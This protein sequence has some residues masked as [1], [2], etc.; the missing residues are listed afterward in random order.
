MQSVRTLFRHLWLG[1]PHLASEP[2]T[3]MFA[4]LRRRL[5]LWYTGVLAGML[6]LFGVVLYLSLDHLLLGPVNT[7]LAH[8]A[9]RYGA[10]WQ[11]AADRDCP[12][13]PDRGEGGINQGQALL[14]ACFNAD[15][16]FQ[17]GYLASNIALSSD[18]FLS[19]SLVNQ[20]LQTGAPQHDIINEGDQ[21]GDVYR[22]AE[23]VVSGPDGSILG[24]IQV[25]ESVDVE[26]AALHLLLILLLILGATTLFA[27]AMGG[28]FLAERALA[29][30]HL[31]FTRQQA[32]IADASHELRTPLTLLR[33]DA[34]V[35]LS[36]RERLAPDDAALLE[37]IV[38]ESEHMTSLANNM[39]TLA[40]LD[41]GRFHLERDVVDLAAVAAGAVHRA[42]AFAQEKQ[43]ALHLEHAGP[44]LVVGDR[45]LLEQAAIILLDNAIKYNRPGG[46]VH[47]SASI[48]GGRACLEISDT[49]M[50]I[51]AEHM[52]HIGERF[53]RVD[54]ARSREMGGAGLGLSIA[55]S[56]AADHGGTLTLS[57]VFGQG[58]TAT[59]SL[60]VAVS[61]PPSPS[62]SEA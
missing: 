27:A 62:L 54:K 47:V 6:L 49:G 35:L 37:D 45:G 46:K 34:E 29:P 48:T 8:L 14:I 58:T 51:P 23:V 38:T 60:P 1:D 30:A 28:L 4:P 31:A 3:L 61:A 41:A 56:V 22:Y 42:S 18:P 32:F 57:S 13:P 40:R 10:F 36:G 59:L 39:L 25:G 19:T 7:D 12:L 5:T 52:P 11:A 55:R 17:Q 2:G 9:D 16:S 44:V 26:E 15:G 50:G 24:V 43:V 53:Y 20:A 21:F 33:A